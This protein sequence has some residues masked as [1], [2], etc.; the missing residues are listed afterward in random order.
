MNKDGVVDQASLTTQRVT[1]SIDDGV[2]SVRLNRA[3]KLNAL[4]VPMLRALVDTGEQLKQDSSVRVVVLSGEGRGFCAGLDV[5]SLQAMSGGE[6]DTQPSDGVLQQIGETGGRVTHLGQQAAYVWQELQCP[7]IAALHGVVLG[8]GCQ[9]ALCADVRIASPDARFSVLEIRW[10]LV[11]DMTG[12]AMLPLLVG[13]DVAKE[14]SFTGRMVSAEEAARIGLVTR[15]S[16]SPLDD[17]LALAQEIARKSPQAIRGVKK[18][19]NRARCASLAEQFRDERE[20]IKPLLGSR[21]QVEAVMAH[22]E[23]RDPVFED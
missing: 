22:L 12:T 10:G 16:D 4:D 2:A 7:V 9:I 11:P 5:G 8:G 3:D 21:N 13:L 14:L 6:A 15:V 19:L 23:K 1:V 20:T 17:A 18:L